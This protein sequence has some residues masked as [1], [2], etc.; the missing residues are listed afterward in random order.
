VRRGLLE[1]VLEDREIAS[2]VTLP[3]AD[4]RAALR[5]NIVR[6]HEV[7]EIDWSRV[8]VRDGQYSREVWLRDPFE[9]ERE[10]V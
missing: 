7:K 1:R 4:T 10:D 9:S 6:T 3:P 8:T 5:M 2:A